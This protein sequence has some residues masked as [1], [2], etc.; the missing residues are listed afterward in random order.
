MVAKDKVFI[1]KAGNG[2]SGCN[3]GRFNIYVYD[4]LEVMRIVE[5]RHAKEI[6][7]FRKWLSEEIKKAERI[8]EVEKI[9][10]L[11]DRL[12]YELKKKA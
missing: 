4:A 3:A 9:R 7:A 11:A 8:A 10:E 1:A 5:K 6:D 12:G 2:I